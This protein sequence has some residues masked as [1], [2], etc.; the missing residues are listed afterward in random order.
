M[1]LIVIDDDRMKIM[2]SEEELSSYNIDAA[3]LDPSDEKTKRI[4]YDIVDRARRSAGLDGARAGM[5]VQVFTSADGGCEMYVTGYSHLYDEDGGAEDM[6]EKKSI[7]VRKRRPVYRFSGVGELL[8]ACRALE[9]R[10]YSE[11][12]DAYITDSGEVYLVLCEGDV[13]LS[14]AL[15]YGDSVFFGGVMMYLSE[16]T[17]QIRERDAVGTLAPLCTNTV[18]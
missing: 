6:E 11:V 14:V 12:S 16:H 18:I 1:E 2:I 17:A 3:T 15:E 9:A 13:D 5:F 4:L 10:G 7:P 8:L